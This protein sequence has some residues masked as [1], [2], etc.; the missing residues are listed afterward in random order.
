[1]NE[2][3]ILKPTPDGG[4]ALHLNLARTS[5]VVAVTPAEIAKIKERVEA[6]HADAHRKNP[7]AVSGDSVPYARREV[8]GLLMRRMAEVTP[9][10][11]MGAAAKKTIQKRVAT[12]TRKPAATAVKKPA[13]PA[14]KPAPKPAA[15]PAPKPAAK[16]AAKP[17]QIDPAKLRAVTNA[18]SILTTRRAKFIAANR[19]KTVD[20]KATPTPSEIATAKSWGIAYLGRKGFPTDPVPTPA[21]PFWKQPTKTIANKAAAAVNAATKEG[22][23]AKIPAPKPFRLER[24]KLKVVETALKTIAS[25]RAKFL[26]WQKKP[27]TP[28]ASADMKLATQWAREFAQ[29]NGVPSTSAPHQFW[30]QSL[31]IITT[32]VSAVVRLAEAQG[33]PAKPPAPVK[34]TVVKMDPKKIAIIRTGLRALAGRRARFLAKE[35][36]A[37]FTSPAD[38]SAGKKFAREHF[39]KSQIPVTYPAPG[40]KGLVQISGWVVMG[41]VPMPDPVT[42]FW[43]QAPAVIKQKVDDALKAAEK[44]APASLP[45]PVPG[46]RPPAPAA[47]PTP[48]DVPGA[49][50]GGDGSAPGDMP[51]EIAE[52]PGQVEEAVGPPPGDMSMPEEP[53]AEIPGELATADMPVEEFPAGDTSY[54]PE[55]AGEAPEEYPGEMALPEDSAPADVPAEEFPGDYAQVEEQPELPAEGVPEEAALIEEYSADS[56]APNESE[57]VE[58]PVAD[59]ETF[60]PTEEE[61]EGEGTM[62]GAYEIGAQPRRP[63]AIAKARY[64]KMVKRC[65]TL[66][67]AK[68]AKTTP[69]PADYAAAKVIVDKKLARRGVKVAGDHILGVSDIM[70]A[71]FIMGAAERGNPKAKAAIKKAVVNAKRG[72]P[73]AKK[74]V[75][76]LIAVAQ[77]KKR[78]QAKAKKPGGIFARYMRA[79]TSHKAA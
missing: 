77:G 24:N 72:N 4:M 51:P 18:L 30:N 22:A 58:E 35:R 6:W 42:A 25:R 13:A 69:T 50:P 61:A 29:K 20:P 52:A 12:G 68:R 36:K 44:D 1:M 71:A 45:P 32:K 62:Y 40:K 38:I 34:P 59:A 75:R 79:V 19:T 67:A 33:A 9:P 43:A 54:A 74:S 55:P 31:P 73:K 66:I 5:F 46:V 70:G 39:I 37:K 26:A 27:G 17:A 14:R 53:P 41:A 56:F 28:V 21:N 63:K 23:P 78:Q 76:A 10:G 60:M 15:R 49:S 7:A 16:P 48:M 57:Y 8:L 11:L 65:A 3:F 64:E 2:A 47:A